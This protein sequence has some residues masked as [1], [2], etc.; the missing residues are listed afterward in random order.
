MS[1][2]PL[3]RPLVDPEQNGPLVGKD[4]PESVAIT[5]PRSVATTGPCV[6]PTVAWL[7]CLLHHG[8]HTHD[9]VDTFHTSYMSV[10]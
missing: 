5:I 3:V 1:Y 7:R 6:S 9:Q 2:S 8:S 10:V 4:Y